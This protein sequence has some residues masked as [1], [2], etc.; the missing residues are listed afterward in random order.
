[1]SK[2]I[3]FTKIRQIKNY[4]KIL[5]RK[6]HKIKA[7]DLEKSENIFENFAACVI[8]CLCN[9]GRL[10]DDSLLKEKQGEAK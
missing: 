6:I 5:E 9:V 10:L 1:M 8:N 2:K 4:C 7:E 3:Y